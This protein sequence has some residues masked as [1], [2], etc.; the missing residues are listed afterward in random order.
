MNLIILSTLLLVLIIDSISI[1][2]SEQTKDYLQKVICLSDEASVS[3]SL[4]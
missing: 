1:L 2:I 4:I 3:K